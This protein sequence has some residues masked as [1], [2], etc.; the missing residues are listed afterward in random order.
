MRISPADARFNLRLSNHAL[1]LLPD[2]SRLVLPN[3]T[4]AKVR[5]AWVQQPLPALR[6]VV[7]L[8]LVP[9]AG[10]S[11]RNVTGERKLARHDFRGIAHIDRR[12]VS[13][14]SWREA[15]RRWV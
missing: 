5:L 12:A 4:V 2:R 14:R 1:S 7:D 10:S 13:R 15:K 6:Y 3:V 9:W 11:A 8:I